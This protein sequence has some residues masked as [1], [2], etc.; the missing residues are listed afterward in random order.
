M[1][2]LLLVLGAVVLLSGCDSLK[3]PVQQNKEAEWGIAFCGGKEKVK[4]LRVNKGD[5]Y[6]SWVLCTDERL[7]SI[8]MQGFTG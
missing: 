3:G 2:K 7:A 6:I 4:E 5:N 1:K 8:P